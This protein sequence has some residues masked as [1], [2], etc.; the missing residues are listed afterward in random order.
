M[1]NGGILKELPSPNPKPVEQRNKCSYMLR[2]IKFPIA[3]FKY[4]SII[5]EQIAPVLTSD[6]V[7]SILRYLNMIPDSLLFTSS[8]L[9]KGHG[10]HKGQQRHFWNRV[11]RAT[12]SSLYHVV[13]TI[14]CAQLLTKSQ[15]W[16]CDSINPKVLEVGSE[17][18]NKLSFLGLACP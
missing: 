7:M 9:A 10:Y 3:N 14:S 11:H 8:G 18:D 17:C 6:G 15:A 2:W 5:V 1:G 13:S 4:V 16:R 12:L